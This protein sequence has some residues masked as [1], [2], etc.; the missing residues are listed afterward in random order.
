FTHIPPIRLKNLAQHAGVI[1][2][3][4]I[5][6]MADDKRIDILLA[7]VKSFEI[8]ALDDALDVLDLLITKIISDAKNLGQKN[9]L[10]TLKDL[11]KSV[12][13]S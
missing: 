10:R 3:P 9:R 6:R 7:F 12:L 4:K 11:D 5:A 1:S 2:M 13:A 8:I